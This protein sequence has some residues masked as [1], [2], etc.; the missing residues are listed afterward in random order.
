MWNILRA[1]LQSYSE[2]L[3]FSQWLLSSAF[4]DLHPRLWFSFQCLFP[5]LLSSQSWGKRLL[6]TLSGSPNLASGGQEK[7]RKIEPP[8]HKSPSKTFSNSRQQVLLTGPFKSDCSKHQCGGSWEGST[9]TGS[10]WSSCR[11]PGLVCHSRGQK[12]MPP[13]SPV[14]GDSTTSSGLNTTKAVICVCPQTLF[15]NKITI[16][17]SKTGAMKSKGLFH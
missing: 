6:H 16:F 5:T 11:E 3:G 14:P 12:I 1:K 13:V 2:S 15:L 17:L 10:S 8:R 9:V 4:H 7:S